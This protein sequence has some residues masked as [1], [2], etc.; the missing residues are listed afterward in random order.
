MPSTH[1]SNPP[2]SACLA[3]CSQEAALAR[4]LQ[5][6]A[7]EERKRCRAEAAYQ[8]RA[9]LLEERRLVRAAAKANVARATAA[10]VQ[11]VHHPPA[12]LL[13]LPALP[14]NGEP[15]LMMLPGPVVEAVPV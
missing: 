10:A 9:Q 12:P 6:I 2:S 7:V 1:A 4:E 5:A 8:K 15:E 13:A 14:L 3:T 11:G